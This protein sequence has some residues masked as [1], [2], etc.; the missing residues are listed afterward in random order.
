MKTEL[1][2]FTK[3]EVH[4]VWS[5]AEPLVEQACNTNGGYNA[6]HILEFLEAGLMQ[7]WMAVDKDTNAVLCCCVTEIRQYP[8]FKVCDLRITTGEQFERWYN[9][10][11]RI[12]EWAK[13]SGCAKMEIFARPGW[14]RILKEKGFKKTH[15]QIEKLL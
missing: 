4:K 12:C 10:M 1:V 3:E 5:L 13:S 11:D 9:Y 6:K 2:N 7:L 14:E 8:N 15:V